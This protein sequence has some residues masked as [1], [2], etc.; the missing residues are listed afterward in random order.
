MLFGTSSGS[1]LFLLICH[2]TGREPKA[3]PL[4][5]ACSL[6]LDLSLGHFAD[7]EQGGETGIWRAALHLHTCRRERAH[8]GAQEHLHPISWALPYFQHCDCCWPRRAPSLWCNPGGCR[9]GSD[10]YWLALHNV[11]KQREQ[12]DIKCSLLFSLYVLWHQEGTLWKGNTANRIQ[13]PFFFLKFLH[14][15]FPFPWRFL[16]SPSRYINS[17]EHWWD[18]NSVQNPKKVF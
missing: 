8:R 14:P 6:W 5:P 1:A 4:P 2:P 13:N 3:T 18:F 15:L 9:I 7:Q 11:H 16:V 12:K 17:V 10:G